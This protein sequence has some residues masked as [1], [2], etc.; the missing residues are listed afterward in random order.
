MWTW[1]KLSEGVRIC[2][3][4]RIVAI[5]V[6]M[7]MAAPAGGVD[8]VARLTKTGDRGA[9]GHMQLVEAMKT[10]GST[11]SGTIVMLVLMILSRSSFM[12]WPTI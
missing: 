3:V 7:A 5:A 2:L 9:A 6:R 1:D 4:L 11:A 8:A 10:N 12:E